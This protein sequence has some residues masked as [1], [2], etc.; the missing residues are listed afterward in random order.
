MTGNT[1]LTLHNDRIE[2]VLAVLNGV[3]DGRSFVDVE[4]DDLRAAVGTI[5]SQYRPDPPGTPGVIALA[6]LPAAG[7]TF[8]GNKLAELLEAPKVSMGDRVR[9][10]YETEFGHPPE[11]GEDIRSWVEDIREDD[12]EII[13]GWTGS[14]IEDNHRDADVVVVDGLRT[15]ADLQALSDVFEPL[16]LIEVKAPFTV[17]L[18]RIQ[19]RGR[20]GEDGY[21]AYD[22]VDRDR[23]E[24][25]WGVQQVIEDGYADL[26]I[27]ND[28]SA[29]A[30]SRLIMNVAESSLPY[31]VPGYLEREN[32]SGDTDMTVGSQKDAPGNDDHLFA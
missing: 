20:E 15:E 7:K 29:P 14:F 31:D 18:E 27:K 9:E 12:P 13:P 19:D 8:V 5:E 21:T 10:M 32:V 1:Q 16:H 11:T 24:M 30:M 26:T 6:G 4:E 17:R 22:L 2:D 28:M 3:L 23:Q 25:E